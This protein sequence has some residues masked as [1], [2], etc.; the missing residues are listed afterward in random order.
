MHSCFPQLLEVLWQTCKILFVI[1]KIQATF[2]VVDV[3]MLD[4]LN[5]LKANV[6]LFYTENQYV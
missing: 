4:I 2:H 3:K 6:D 5:I 1:S